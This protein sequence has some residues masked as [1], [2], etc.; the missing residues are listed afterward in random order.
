MPRRTFKERS[1]IC[2]K[3]S[4][5]QNLDYNAQYNLSEARPPSVKPKAKLVFLTEF[6]FHKEE[7]FNQN[8][9]IFLQ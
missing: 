9:S 5:L 8:V 7:I 1:N 6:M 3:L 4:I 2:F